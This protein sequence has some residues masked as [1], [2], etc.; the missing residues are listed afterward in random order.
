LV[1]LVEETESYIF[2]YKPNSDPASFGR[3]LEGDELRVGYDME[4]KFLAGLTR[5]K[6]KTLSGIGS[7]SRVR[8]G[9]GRVTG[10][11]LF[12]YLGAI[13]LAGLGWITARVTGL[14]HFP[15]PG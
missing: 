11:R 4:T 10:L 9:L 7:G 2:I 6:A 3:F 15:Y 5:I 14:R 8:S 1:L 12:P 13:W